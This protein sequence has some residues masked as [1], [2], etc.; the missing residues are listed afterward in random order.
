MFDVFAILGKGITL[1]T[2]KVN[3]VYGVCKTKLPALSLAVCNV[4][5]IVELPVGTV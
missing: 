2:V 1:S 3:P 4:V 5:V